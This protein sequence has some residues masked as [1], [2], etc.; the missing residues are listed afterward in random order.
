MLVI[1]QGMWQARFGGRPD[2]V[3]QPVRLSGEPY[4]I[5]GV[6][7]DVV[8]PGWPSNPAHV[9]IDRELREFWVPIARTPELDANVRS[10]VFG[11]VV[12]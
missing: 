4:V 10:H 8:T 5:V 2:I 9:A 11:V 7:P 3:G 6:M 1:S 12:D